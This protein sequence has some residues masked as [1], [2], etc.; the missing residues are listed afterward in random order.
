MPCNESTFPNM[1][2]SV[3]TL[4]LLIK[5]FW[6]CSFWPVWDVTWVPTGW[7]DLQLGGQEAKKHNWG[8]HFE[9]YIIHHQLQLL[10]SPMPKKHHLFTTTLQLFIRSHHNLGHIYQQQLLVG[11]LEHVF[12]HSVGNVII[13]TDEHIFQRGRLNH[14]PVHLIP[15]KITIYR[16]ISHFP[17]EYTYDPTSIPLIS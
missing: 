10:T 13:P 3:E 2:Y 17:S 4:V 5:F 16:W 9:E 7:V 14:Q 11:G 12:F 6:V 1:R 8:Q 15:I